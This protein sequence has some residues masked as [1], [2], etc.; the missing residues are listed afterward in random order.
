MLWYKQ[1]YLMTT[2]LLTFWKKMKT[3]WNTIHSKWMNAADF[4]SATEDHKQFLGHVTL[5]N[6]REPYSMRASDTQV[7]GNHYKRF[8]IQPYEYCYKNRLNN[9]Q[10]EA[11]SYISRYQ[12]KWEGNKEKQIED[13]K[14]AI[15]TLELLVQELEDS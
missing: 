13:V 5:Q 1:I 14:K 12:Y 10:S 15:H 3:I 7:A 6:Q 2:N 9:L 11:I 4:Q 8:A